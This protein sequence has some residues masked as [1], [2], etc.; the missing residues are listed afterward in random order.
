MLIG[1]YSFTGGVM[2][3]SL[4]LVVVLGVYGLIVLSDFLNNKKRP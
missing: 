2:S 4:F 1:G 3:F